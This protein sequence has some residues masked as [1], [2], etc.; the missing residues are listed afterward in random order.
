MKTEEELIWES[1]KS[2]GKLKVPQTIN[3]QDAAYMNAV[4]RGDMK[5]AQR[6]VD[7]AAKRAGYN[8]GPEFHK[9][10]AKFTKFKTSKGAFGEGIYFYPDREAAEQWL[11]GEDE[12]IVISA[13]L[14]LK[15]PFIYE[16][17]DFDFPEKFPSI[18]SLRKKGHDGVVV[19]YPD[20]YKETLVFRPNQIKSADPA[21]YDSEGNLIPLSQRFDSTKDDIIY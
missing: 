8:V 4:E 3:D 1:Y 17:S 16:A 14:K 21:T 15:S 9:T 11:S 13:W 19:V 6:M 2:V 12:E 20:D 5:T 18:K 10:T 7:D